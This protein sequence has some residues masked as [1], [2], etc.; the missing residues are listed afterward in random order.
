MRDHVRILGWCFIVYHIV[1]AL[2]GL[3]I[4]AIVFTGGALSGER[5]VALLTGAVGAFIA[6][7]LLLLSLPG[8][9]TGFGLLKFRPWARILAIILG[10]LHLLSFPFG[11][12]LGVFA[13]YVLLNER[14]AALFA[15]PIAQP[16]A[17]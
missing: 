10:A 17:F 5:D 4:G 13:L 16:A 6:G 14:N 15:A 3:A 7:L 1:V 8:I 2:I 9:I 12:A 11:T